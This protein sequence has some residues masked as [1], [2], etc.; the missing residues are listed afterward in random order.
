MRTRDARVVA[1][2]RAHV[3]VSVAHL[4]RTLDLERLASIPKSSLFCF[5]C[6]KYASFAGIHLAS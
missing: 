4:L 2:T 1:V 6:G 3:V 5:R